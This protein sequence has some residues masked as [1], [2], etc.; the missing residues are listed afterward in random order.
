MAL[1][2]ITLM[3]AWQL[4]QELE[5]ISED[6]DVHLVPALCPLDVFPHDFSATKELIERAARTTTKWITE[7]GLTRRVFPQEIVAHIPWP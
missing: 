3:I 7:G 5:S 1:H 4:M 2:A 6:I